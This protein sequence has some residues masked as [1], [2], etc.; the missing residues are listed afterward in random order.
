MP[1][2]KHNFEAIGTY[3]S[4]ETD[5]PLSMSL[6][7]RI[8]SCIESFD[9]TFSRFKADS[10]VRRI[11][12][13]GQGSYAFP[14][15]IRQIMQTYST[16]HALS[17][18][19]INPLV[20]R[21][22]EQLGYDASYSLRAR[23]TEPAPD[24]SS[25]LTMTSKVMTTHSHVLF[26]IGAIGKGLLVDIIAALVASDHKAYVVDGSG[27]LRVNSQTAELIGLEDPADP[28]RVIGQVM[29]TTG[30]LCASATN[31]RAWGDGLH[32]IV[33]ATTGK[34]T[35]GNAIATWAIAKTT[36]LA[37][38]LTTGLFFISPNKLMSEFEAF[39]YVILNRDGSIAH[40]ITPDVGEIYS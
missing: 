6:I 9:Q 7:A 17:S 24:F 25:S 23:S 34:P 40:N 21:S 39:H 19:S 37:D 14:P 32:H 4:I 28:S 35:Q 33:D 20:G 22:L 38:A 36:M 15:Q 30:G 10:L 16:L 12:E 2:H 5:A 31:R 3:W 1:R 29:L 11:Y 26:D 18:G 13:Q 27:D 8:D